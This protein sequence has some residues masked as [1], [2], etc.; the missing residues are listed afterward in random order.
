MLPIFVILMT[1]FPIFSSAGNLAARSIWFDDASCTQRVRENVWAEVKQMLTLGGLSLPTQDGD[2]QRFFAYL[3]KSTDTKKQQFIFDSS[4]SIATNT[5]NDRTSA[6]VRIYCDGDRRWQPATK[7]QVP[8]NEDR[9][10]NQKA[11]YDVGNE[12][13]YDVEGSRPNCM[14]GGLSGAQAQTYSNSRGSSGVFTIT[15]C[16]A[17]LGQ[18]ELALSDSAGTDRANG[19]GV[20]LDQYALLSTTILHEI[21]HTLENPKS[22]TD[23]WID[24]GG[25]GGYR[26]A[27]VYGMTATSALGN[28]ESFAYFG[29]GALVQSMGYSIGSDGIIY[30]KGQIPQSIAELIVNG[31]Q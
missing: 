19:G 18:A 13:V 30:P 17:A 22:R 25:K 11:W 29:L 24:V 31:F 26:W 1:F 16:D 15:L 21:A 20:S 12:M 4:A 5:V 9:P 3:F 6:N 7:E 2:T 28:A 10:Q 14:Q 27:G 8:G 23:R